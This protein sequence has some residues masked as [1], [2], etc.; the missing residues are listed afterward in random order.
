MHKKK[1]IVGIVVVVIIAAIPLSFD[2]LVN[3]LGRS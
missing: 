3:Q 1:W 2:S